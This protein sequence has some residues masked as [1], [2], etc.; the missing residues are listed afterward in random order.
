[1]ERASSSLIVHQPHE[2]WGR[3]RNGLE[4]A[5]I[6]ATD[7]CHNLYTWK[8]DKIMLASGK[9]KCLIFINQPEY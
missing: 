8:K 2:V 3:F 6:A 9:G 5:V 1:M 7:P 4:L